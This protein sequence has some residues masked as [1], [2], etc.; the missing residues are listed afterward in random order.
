MKKL[1]HTAAYLAVILTVISAFFGCKTTGAA[2]AKTAGGKVYKEELDHKY[3]SNDKPKPDWITQNKRTLEASDMYRG[4]KLYVYESEKEKDLELARLW[5]KNH[6]APSEVVREIKAFVENKFGS[7]P[8]ISK[9]ER[10]MY[11]AVRGMAKGNIAGL[12][13][14]DDYWVLNRYY[15]ANGKVEG[16]YYTVYVL[17]SIPQNL[18]EKNLKQAIKDKTSATDDEIDNFLKGVFADDFGK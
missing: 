12:V 2:V 17:Y 10:K 3:K 6:S 14:E 4:Y 11:D 7:D 16:D 18:W 13:R 8:N 5:I 9:D 15:D 1:I